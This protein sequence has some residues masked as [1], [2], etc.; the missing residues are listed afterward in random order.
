MAPTLNPEIR[1]LESQIR[2]KSGARTPKDRVPKGRRGALFPADK[3]SRIQGFG[4]SDYQPGAPVQVAALALRAQ[5]GTDSPRS[6]RLSTCSADLCN[7]WL[8]RRALRR[9]KDPGFF[10]PVGVESQPCES[11]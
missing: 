9:V 11:A 2:K 10:N 3:R 1:S 8:R 4:N 6:V 5:F 7:Q